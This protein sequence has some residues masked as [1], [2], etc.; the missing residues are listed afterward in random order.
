MTSDLLKKLI[1]WLGT[2]KGIFALTAGSIAGTLSIIISSK[3]LFARLDLHALCSYLSIGLPILGLVALRGNTREEF[4]STQD[5]STVNEHA[6]EDLKREMETGWLEE[7]WH[8]ES[9]PPAPPPPAPWVSAGRILLSTL[10]NPRQAFLEI[11]NRLCLEVL[12]FPLIFS[13]FLAISFRDHT[14]TWKMD[15]LVKLVAIPFYELGK[16]GLIMIVAKLLRR[17]LCFRSAVLAAMVEDLAAAVLM[18]LLVPFP[19]LIGQ[20]GHALFFRPGLGDVIAGLVSTHTM[21]FHLLAEFHL[22]M[23]WGFFLWWTGLTALLDL[24]RR[25]ALGAALLTYPVIHFSLCPA[26]MLSR[27]LI[28]W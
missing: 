26:L 6:F 7:Q 18:M 11:K 3:T 19:G 4:T 27:A 21:F 17:P 24:N 5:S 14:L 23:L 8:K 13:I 16:A 20:A 28:L 1:G 22:F 25:Q 15:Y 9:I 12:I 10:I 2:R